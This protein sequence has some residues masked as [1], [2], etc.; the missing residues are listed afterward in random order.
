MASAG[1]IF[2]TAMS[3]GKVPRHDRGADAERLAQRV[4]EVVALDRD[5]LAHHLVGPAAVVLEALGRGRDLD[6]AGLADRLAV[7]Q[8]L[9]AR[10][11]RRRA[12]SAA[13]RACA[14]GVRA[15]APTSAPTVRSARRARRRRRRSDPSASA[16]A[17][18]AQTSSV[19]G[20]MTSIVL[21]DAAARHSLLMKSCFCSAAAI[22]DLTGYAPG[23]IGTKSTKHLDRLS[24][25]RGLASL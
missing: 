22:H 5:R 25:R 12:P 1:A 8:R 18:T 10:D 4:I 17:T 6:V 24:R 2:Q 13:R 3:S 14:P 20:L 9:E 7:V 23:H 15:R 21:P 16:D 11:T 19:A